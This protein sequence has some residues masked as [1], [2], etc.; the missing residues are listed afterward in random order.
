MV[1]SKGNY[2]SDLRVENTISKCRKFPGL[3]K[4]D[5]P[6]RKSVFNKCSVRSSTMNHCSSNHQIDPQNTHSNSSK[7]SGAFPSCDDA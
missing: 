6:V 4:T 3:F 5:Y 2:K 1:D 7:L